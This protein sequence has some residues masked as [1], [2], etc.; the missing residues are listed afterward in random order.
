MTDRFASHSAGFGLTPVAELTGMSGRAALQAMIDGEAPAPPF[1]RWS[2][3]RL[4]EVGEGRAVFEGEPTEAMLNPL[5]TVHGGWTAGI[6]DSAMACA[7][8]ATLAPGEAYTTLEYKVH[9]VRPITPATG[10]VRCEGV[11]L[12]RARRAATAE[13]RLYDAAGK[14]LAHGTETCL[15]FEA[16]RAQSART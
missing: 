4:V 10:L 11:V 8:H 16:P 7:V 1:A 5:G 9:C 12:S 13:G 14:L 6:L 15:V 3:V 2:R